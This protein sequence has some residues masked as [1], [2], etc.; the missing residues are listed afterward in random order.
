MGGGGKRFLKEKIS[1]RRGFANQMC[2]ENNIT[3]IK[4]LILI[5]KAI[6]YKIEK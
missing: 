5:K 1:F 3:F 4:A 2:M 6:K